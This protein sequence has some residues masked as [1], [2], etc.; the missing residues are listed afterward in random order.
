MMST[1]NSNEP[2]TPTAYAR[3][4]SLLVAPADM[5]A[6]YASPET[7]SCD[8]AQELHRKFP[9]DVQA[10][11]AQRRQQRAGNRDLERFDP[12]DQQGK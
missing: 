1:T 9:G 7:Q 10:E 12:G 8:A 3:S 4:V 2:P 6:E 5:V 11:I